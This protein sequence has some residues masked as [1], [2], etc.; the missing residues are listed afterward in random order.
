[1][2]VL[3]VPLWN[4]NTNRQRNRSRTT[5]I[6]CTVVELKHAWPGKRRTYRWVLIVPLWNWN[7][8]IR[9]T[10]YNNRQC[11]NCTVVELKLPKP[12]RFSCLFSSINCTVVELKLRRITSSDKVTNVLIVPLWNWNC[13]CYIFRDGFCLCINC[14]VV[15]LKHTIGK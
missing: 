4:W 15:E 8:W 2:H 13:Y 10:V 5:G 11:I 3:I 14:T 6:N 7:R 9:S 1:M 12:I